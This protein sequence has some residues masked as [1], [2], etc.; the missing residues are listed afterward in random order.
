MSKCSENVKQWRS[1]VK[2]KIVESMGNKC[3]ICGYNRCHAALELHHI[4]PSE[5]EFTF[6]TVIA[7]PRAWHKIEEELK[8]CILL[9][10]NCHREIHS[11]VVQIPDMYQE[12]NASLI[13]TPT[14]T[15][16]CIV[17]GKDTHI[18]NRCCSKVCSAS[19][20][21]TVD[22]SSINLVDELSDKSLTQ[23]GEK[24]GV[25]GQA[26]KRQCTK[27]GIDISIITN[28]KRSMK[29]KKPRM[30]HRKVIRP[31]K[32]DFT[33]LLNMHSQTDIG[34]MFNVSES[35]IR[36]WKKSYNIL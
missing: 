2:I 34:K 32:E 23:V 22:W 7:N 17:C 31:S 3:Q 28:K 14:P 16:P 4:N 36:K 1:S 13:K 35:A 12:F 9:C 8:K 10:S 29:N 26:V 15:K 21:N 24:Y 27:Q 18:T 30:D 5:K 20:S 25:T 33:T 6:G 19:L 11:N